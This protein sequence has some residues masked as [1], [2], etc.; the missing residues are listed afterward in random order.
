MTFG[1]TELILG[2]SRAKKCEES[3][4][5]VHF[6]V[7]PQKYSKNT[8]TQISETEQIQKKVARFQKMKCWET[9]ET[10][11]YKVSSQTEPCL[12]GKWPFEVFGK[13][14]CRK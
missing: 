3:D 8:E 14:V 9:S 6:D 12:M 13:F 1:R 7:A 11:F 4:F 5:V 2:A 10:C